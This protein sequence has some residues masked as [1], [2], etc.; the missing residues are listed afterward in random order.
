MAKAKKKR[1]RRALG[2]SAEAHM[3][4]AR[5]RLKSADQTIS[6]A[7]QTALRGSCSHAVLLLVAGAAELGHAKAHDLQRR[8]GRRGIQAGH[9]GDAEEA[10]EGQRRDR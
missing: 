10:D 4:V 7:A 6:A 5:G 2:S 9:D 8:H 1:S 3:D